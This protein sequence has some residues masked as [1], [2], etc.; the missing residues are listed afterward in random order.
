MLDIMDIAYFSYMEEQ[1][2]KHKELYNRSPISQND[3]V[4]EETTQNKE[5]EADN[6][7]SQNYP[8]YKSH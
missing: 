3:T 8:P 2:K 6:I 1:E 7:L 4:G 5:N